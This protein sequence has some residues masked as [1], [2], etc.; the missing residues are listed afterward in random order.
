MEYCG[1]AMVCTANLCHTGVDSD[2]SLSPAKPLLP[3]L[4]SQDICASA[5]L[6]SRAVEKMIDVSARNHKVPGW[7]GGRNGGAE[8]GP[9]CV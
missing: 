5:R 6:G 1:L 4:S 3:S 9:R 8:L 2:V 7:R